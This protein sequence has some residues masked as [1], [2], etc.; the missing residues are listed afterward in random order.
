MHQSRGSAAPACNIPALMITD[1]PRLLAPTIESW[2]EDAL[3][4]PECVKQLSELSLEEEEQ[5]ALVGK[6]LRVREYTTEETMITRNW[7]ASG[8]GLWTVKSIIT[9]SN[10]K[11][12]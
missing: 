5:A 2:L 6:D 10:F 1:P 12:S 7:L 9:V 8:T 4:S 3:G 11:N